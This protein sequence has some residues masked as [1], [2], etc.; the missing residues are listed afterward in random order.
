[1][2]KRVTVLYTVHRYQTFHAE[3][4]FLFLVQFRKKISAKEQLPPAR[5]LVLLQGC[6]LYVVYYTI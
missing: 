4:S 5:Q 2:W 1:M 3:P 6:V